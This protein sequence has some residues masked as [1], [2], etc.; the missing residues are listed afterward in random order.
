MNLF[1]EA[2]Q[3]VTLRF[4]IDGEECIML[5][6]SALNTSVK[7][8]GVVHCL[9]HLSAQGHNHY[10]IEICVLTTAKSILCYQIKCSHH[11]NSKKRTHLHLFT[12]ID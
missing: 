1:Q 11:L 4:S 6:R 3:G 2:A 12:S 8:C 7:S 10:A 5:K 9:I